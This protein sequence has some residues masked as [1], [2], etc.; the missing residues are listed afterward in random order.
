MLSY[1]LACVCSEHF[2]VNSFEVPLRERLLNYT[3]KNSRHLK[4]D[5]VPTLKLPGNNGKEN[6][7]QAEERSDRSAKRMRRGEVNDM[8]KKHVSEAVVIDANQDNNDT[9]VSDRQ[10]VSELLST[11]VDNAETN[12]IQVDLASELKK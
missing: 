6:K 7:R 12:N 9:E 2:E 1:F 4:H 10:E 3:F 5:A 11:T 8:L